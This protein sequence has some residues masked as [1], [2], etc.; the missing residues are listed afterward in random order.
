MVHWYH[1]R[2]PVL[3]EYLSQ[4]TSFSSLHVFFD[5]SMIFF[6]RKSSA[7][8]MEHPAPPRTRLWPRAMYFTP[9]R[10]GSRRTR[11]TVTVI[12]FPRRRR[13][14]SADDLPPPGQ[15]SDGPG[16]RGA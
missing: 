6:A 2:L 3:S 15:Q 11:P 16:L 7:L 10:A 13:A 12:P 9:P 4:S 8:R 1:H 14:L 5:H